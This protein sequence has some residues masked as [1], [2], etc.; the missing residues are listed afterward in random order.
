MQQQE[1][2][3]SAALEQLLA[4]FARAS[5]NVSRRQARWESDGQ[6]R[7]EEE[8]ARAAL[9]RALER[10][11]LVPP[12]GAAVPMRT[13]SDGGELAEV[14]GS[15]RFHLERMSAN[16][17]WLVFEAEGRRIDVWLRAG[18]KISATFESDEAMSPAA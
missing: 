7:R 17:W 5:S 6:A 10:P 13:R 4:E 15:G 1:K 11:A 14:V 16:N 3:E 9:C 18:G 2:S 8:S 12:E